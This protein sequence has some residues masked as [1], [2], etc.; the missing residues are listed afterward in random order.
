MKA[1]MPMKKSLVSE[2]LK[3]KL[4]SIID[5]I[6]AEKR[7]EII[8]KVITRIDTLVANT[9]IKEAKKQL[10]IEL[11]QLLQSKL[12]NTQTEDEILNEIIP[13]E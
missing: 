12:N 5:K 9:A 10:L 2:S 6:P 3:N 1:K 8:N 4:F 7:T 11:K 13:A